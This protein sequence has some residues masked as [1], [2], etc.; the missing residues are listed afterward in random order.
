RRPVKLPCRR[1]V[2]RRA[3][4]RR[5]DLNLGIF[6]PEMRGIMS[7]RSQRQTDGR[8]TAADVIKF[9]ELV[10]VVPEGRLVGQPLKL[11]DFQKDFIREIYDNPA[12]TR[13]AIMSCPRKN[14]KTQLIACLVLAHLCGPP[15]QA[16]RNSNIFSAA[17]SREQAAIVF[18]LCAKMV[19]MNPQL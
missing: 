17:M 12:G 3:R 10:A 15:A 4:R 2:P 18:G 16:R 7:T 19:R 8:V 6:G 9:V 14:G 1:P 5:R 11:L 13:R